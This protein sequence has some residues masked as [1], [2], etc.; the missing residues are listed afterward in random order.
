MRHA[1]IFSLKGYTGKCSD[2]FSNDKTVVV[3]YDKTVHVHASTYLLVVHYL[4]VPVQSITRTTQH[5]DGGGG[6]TAVVA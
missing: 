5:H 4:L 2:F 3:S 1:T 6:T